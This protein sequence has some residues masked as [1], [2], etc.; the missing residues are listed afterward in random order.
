[1]PRAV[2]ERVYNAV[3]DKRFFNQ[4]LDTLGKRRIH[5]LQ[6]LVATHRLLAYGISAESVDNYCKLSKSSALGSLKEF[7]RGGN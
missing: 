5:L 7:L 2:F 6:L 3:K 4:N 1:M